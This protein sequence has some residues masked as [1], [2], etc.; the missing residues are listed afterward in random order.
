MFC[1]KSASRNR[2][3]TG[4]TAAEM[5]NIDSEEEPGIDETLNF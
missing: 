4:V 1:A 2:Q 5:T 3:S